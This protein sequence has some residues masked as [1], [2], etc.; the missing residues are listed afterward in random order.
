MKAY[1]RQGTHFWT[2]HHVMERGLETRYL[3]AGLFM[4]LVYSITRSVGIKATFLK[5]MYET[6]KYDFLF[7]HHIRPNSDLLQPVTHEKGCIFF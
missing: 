7:I 6:F 1:Y 2:P 3:T 5:E 4:A